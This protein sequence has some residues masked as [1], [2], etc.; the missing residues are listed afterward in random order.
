[1]R[2]AVDHLI[3]ELRHRFAALPD[4]VEYL[5]RV[6]RDVVDAAPEFLAAAGP[7]RSEQRSQSV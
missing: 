3:D 7:G 1:M 5:D 2:A 6:E 4:V